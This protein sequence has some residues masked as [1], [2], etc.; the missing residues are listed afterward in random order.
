MSFIQSLLSEHVLR[1]SLSKSLLAD[2]IVSASLALGV[3]CA[4][5]FWFSPLSH[6]PGPLSCRLGL[7]GWQTI[8]A[9]KLDF[10][11]RV[12]EW[13]DKTGSPLIR[14]GPNEISCSDPSVIPLLYK[15]LDKT[16]FYSL[17]TFTSVDTMMSIRSHELHRKQ[18]QSDG[19]LFTKKNLAELEHVFDDCVDSFQ[20]CLDREIAAGNRAQ[21]FARLLRYYT[22][23]MIGQVV[24]GERFGVLATNTDPENI[25]DRI[26]LAVYGITVGGVHNWIVPK[27]LKIARHFDLGDVNFVRKRAKN[28]LNQSR[29]RFEASGKQSD[30]LMSK[31]LTL[32]HYSG[33]SYTEE[34][35]QG[36]AAV[37]FAAG[38]DTTAIVLR[39]FVY[40]LIEN[41]SCQSRL[42]EEL[43]QAVRDN[44]LTLPSPL[45]DQTLR[46]DYFQ[47]CLW[48]TIRMWPSVHWLLP[49]V[50]PPTGLVLPTCSNTFLPAGTEIGISAYVLHHDV[51]T[52]GPDANQFNPDRWINVQDL[53][54]KRR[55]MNNILSFGWG[56]RVC[57]GK[58]LALMAMSKVLPGLILGYEFEWIKREPGSQHKFVEGRSQDGKEGV[59]EP[60]LAV[61]GF[62]GAQ[63]DMW[64]NVS[65]RQPIE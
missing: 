49:R 33:R 46:L 27:L 23:D 29:A 17:F 53:Q 25:L 26:D 36:M 55:M 22:L 3:Y 10:G 38:T 12:K 24:F 44:T 58:N 43:R 41:P 1:V 2:A 64:L 7:P 18:I 57:L 34:E 19:K 15:T 11:P 42:V 32:D 65:P 40:Y 45:Y 52:F 60:M 5:Q 9:F 28:C 30:D 31:M 59:D 51:R 35:I 13:H 20:A 63:F 8:R 14:I 56:S 16:A 47:A 50:V 61:S 54:D 4:Y 37:F 48:E 62:L 21:D 39:A 6:I